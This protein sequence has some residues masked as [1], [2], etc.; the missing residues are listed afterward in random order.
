MGVVL[1]RELA[2]GRTSVWF[3]ERKKGNLALKRR[4]GHNRK[5]PCGFVRLNMAACKEQRRDEEER[6]A[7]SV[8]T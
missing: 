8:A 7:L 6:M 1:W 3:C 2:G 4:K 5:P